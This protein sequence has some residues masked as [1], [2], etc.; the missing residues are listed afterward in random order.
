MLLDLP[1]NASVQLQPAPAGGLG[2]IPRFTI[3]PERTR[4]TV[5]DSPYKQISRA[6][7]WEER[8]GVHS[9]L[10][11]LPACRLCCQDPFG[12]V[13]LL[14]LPFS[15]TSPLVPSDTEVGWPHLQ[16]FFPHAL[17]CLTRCQAHLD[18]VQETDL[19]SPEKS[20]RPLSDLPNPLTLFADILYHGQLIQTQTPA[21]IKI[22]FFLNTA[23]DQCANEGNQFHSAAVRPDN[24]KKCIQEA[25]F[26]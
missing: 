15:Y 3:A 24:I 9:A 12:F 16:L 10:V 7:F 25:E 18:N 14:H 11:K 4:I 19:I 23:E 22:T 17:S 5:W 6:A 8:K 13:S 26:L 21:R 20:I 2:H 1:Q